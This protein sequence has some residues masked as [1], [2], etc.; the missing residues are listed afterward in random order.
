MRQ[1]GE[2]QRHSRIPM[3]MSQ[4]MRFTRPNAIY[5]TLRS[6][7]GIVLVCRMVFLL[8]WGRGKSVV[9]GEAARLVHGFVSMFALEE[10]GG[11]GKHEPGPVEAA[12]AGRALEHFHGLGSVHVGVAEAQAG[13]L[14]EGPG[15]GEF[16]VYLTD[17][18]GTML[19]QN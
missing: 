3:S 5:P 16:D 14:E 19:L 9:L 11:H 8:R 1:F 17:E 15:G 2:R 18:S 10:G 13:V 6:E 12:V 4:N 7:E